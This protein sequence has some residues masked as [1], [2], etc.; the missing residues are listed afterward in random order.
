MTAALEG[1][2]WS[3]ARPGR[4]LPPGKTQYPFYR[5]LGGPQSQSERAENFVL[6]GIFFFFFFFRSR[7]FQPLASRYTDW[8]TGPTNYWVLRFLNDN[9][10]SVTATRI[11]QCSLIVKWYTASSTPLPK[12]TKW[13][14]FLMNVKYRRYGFIRDC[15]VLQNVLRVD[16]EWTSDFVGEVDLLSYYHYFF[17]RVSLSDCLKIIIFRFSKQ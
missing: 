16:S 13:V 15:E 8:A 9:E 10:V 11:T 3:A 2:E 12:F 17:L 1:S 4:S 14:L 7:T 5:R 6:T